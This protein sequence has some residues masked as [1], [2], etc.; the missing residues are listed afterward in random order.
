[1]MEE[2]EGAT[3]YYRFCRQRKLLFHNRENKLFGELFRLGKENK[4]IKRK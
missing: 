1:M 3:F 2:R 4:E